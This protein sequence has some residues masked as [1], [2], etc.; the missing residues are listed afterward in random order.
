MF[1]SI[2]KSDNNQKE[3]ESPQEIKTQRTGKK[4]VPCNENLESI[5]IENLDRIWV[6][7]LK[8]VNFV[9]EF[10]CTWFCA[11]SSLLGTKP[12]KNNSPQRC[13]K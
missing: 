3:V 1:L 7:A 2:N 5:F 10:L 4:T 11:E 8:T 6:V 13:E 9:K 12:K